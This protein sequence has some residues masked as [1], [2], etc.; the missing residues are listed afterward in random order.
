MYSLKT[1][2]ICAILLLER[3]ELKCQPDKKCGSQFAKAEV[4]FMV[5]VQSAKGHGNLRARLRRYSVV[6]LL[7]LLPLI[8]LAVYRYYP[9]FLQFVLAF[10]EYKLFGGIWGSEWIGMENFIEIFTSNN[11]SRIFVNT[12][13]ISILRLVV[14]FFPPILLAIMLFD[15][16]SNRFRKISQS[17]LYVPHFFSWVVIYG[18]VLVMFQ[19]D[20]YINN[21]RAACGLN[22]V[23]F[24][25]RQ[26]YFLPILIGTGLWKELGWSTIIYLAALTGINPELF[27]VAKIDG[28]GPLRR[29]WHVTLPGILPVVVFV[30]TMSLGRLLSAAGTEQILLFYSPSNYNISDTIGTWVYRQGLGSMEYGLSAAVAMVESSIGLVL[31]LVCNRVATKVAGV[32]IW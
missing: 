4:G 32:G 6:Y 3:L 12:F 18:I 14:G 16:T 1:K 21:I 26:E 11:I 22:R 8:Y 9:I 23:E 15:M 20:G 27:E 13:R 24:L 5:H 19:N 25:M 31:I 30:L 17:I 2:G 28:A 29:I 10:K 7:I